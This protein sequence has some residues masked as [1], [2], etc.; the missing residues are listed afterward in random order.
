MTSSSKQPEKAQDAAWTARLR[1]SAAHLLFPAE[2]SAAR[3]KR[4]IVLFL[5]VIALVLA[6]DLYS[7]HWA[8]ETVAGEPV[9]LQW[10]PADQEQAIPYHRP[11]V[12][13]ENILAL[14]LTTNRGAVFGLMAGSQWFF[15]VISV[16]AVVLISL[17]FAHSRKNSYALHIALAMLLAGALGNL[18]DRMTYNAVRDLLW[19]FPDVHLPFGLSWP[20]LFG[21]STQVFPWIFNIAD[22]ALNVGVMMSLFLVGREPQPEADDDDA[23]DSQPADLTRPR[24]GPARGRPAPESAHAPK[25]D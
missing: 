10:A 21:G 7:K 17:F 16:V 25:A 3:S 11:I 19:I 4:A 20:N 2:A 22:V 5:A 15:V 13:V 8:F 24:G 23:Q 9:D 6:A 14:R 12:V 18:Y 1:S